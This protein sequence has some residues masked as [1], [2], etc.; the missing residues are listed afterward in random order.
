MKKYILQGVIIWGAIG[1][2]W[3]LFI[4]NNSKV[5]NKEKYYQDKIDS[6]QIEIGLNKNKIDSLS[7]A[8]VILD[9]IVAVDKAKLTEVSKKA[10][11]YRKKYNEEH[12]RISDMSDDDIIREFTAA[13]Q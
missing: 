7:A 9:S 1:L 6:L 12:N 10:E 4:Y 3:F 5:S 13:F 11:T 2:L 8:K